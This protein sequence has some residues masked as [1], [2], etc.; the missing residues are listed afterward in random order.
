[1]LCKNSEDKRQS[2]RALSG[3]LY[4]DQSLN[5]GRRESFSVVTSPTS[6]LVEIPKSALTVT[7]LHYFL[8][9]V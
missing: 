5:S 3:K 8:E 4:L 9:I 1:M 6:W 2:E 7:F